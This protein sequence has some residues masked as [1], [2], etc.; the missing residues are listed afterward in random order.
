MEENICHTNLKTTRSMVILFDFS[1]LVIM[2]TVCI[3]LRVCLPCNCYLVVNY[4]PYG[5]KECLSSGGHL[6]WH[7]GEHGD[8]DFQKW[9]P[10]SQIIHMES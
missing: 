2:Q 6:V 8:I 1:H 4:M 7:I 10:Q 3:V 9:F 5:T